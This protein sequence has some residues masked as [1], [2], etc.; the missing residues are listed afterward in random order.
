MIG[1]GK[2]GFIIL[3]MGFTAW[4]VSCEMVLVSDNFIRL[5]AGILIG[6]VIEYLIFRYQCAPRL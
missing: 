6:E 4:A 1:S 2:H 5:F 3:S